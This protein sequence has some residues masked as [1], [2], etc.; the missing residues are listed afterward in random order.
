M[1][2]T[3]ALL[4]LGLSACSNIHQGKSLKG[5]TI[6]SSQKQKKSKEKN[7]LASSDSVKG[8]KL[9]DDPGKNEI[10]FNSIKVNGNGQSGMSLKEVTKLMGT[11]PDK[12]QQ[13]NGNNVYQYT[14]YGFSDADYDLN[15]SPKII[16][17]VKNNL[18]VNKQ[19]LGLDV[20]R[21][22]SLT[23]NDFKGL[24]GGVSIDDVIQRIGKP[25]EIYVTGEM[26][27]E[28]D[29]A[30]TWVYKTDIEGLDNSDSSGITLTFSPTG[31]LKDSDLSAFNDTDNQ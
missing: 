13:E 30:V 27:S 22:D 20:V 25:T 10:N 5:K 17:I 4:T 14:W 3:I 21:N 23:E 28:D 9:K 29:D 8:S 15:Y 7:A 1:I 19:L 2:L 26:G 16:I 31:Y 24:P 11:S 6:S 12:T 18:V